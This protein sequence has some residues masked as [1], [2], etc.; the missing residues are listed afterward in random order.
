MIKAIGYWRS[1]QASKLPDPRDF[2]DDGWR[3]DDRERLAH[4][5]EMAPR[6]NAWLGYSFCRFE[7][8]VSPEEMGDFEM[9]DGVYLWPQGLAHYVSVHHVRLPDEFVERMRERGF[10]PPPDRL[11]LSGD[12]QQ[13]RE[14]AEKAPSI[15][16]R[17]EGIRWWRA[18]AENE[19]QR[20]QSAPS[21]G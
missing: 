9:S 18:W 16:A 6:V 3:V 20:K 15:E 4:Y 21:T 8:G 11:P 17:N 2:I 1:E 5:L 10:E 14:W 7:C 13:M 12:Q 19:L